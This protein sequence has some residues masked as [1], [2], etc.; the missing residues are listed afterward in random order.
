MQTI[1][2]AE[3]RPMTENH[4]LFTKAEEAMEK[5]FSDTSVELEM[6]LENMQALKD[7]I[8]ISISAL[9]V[10]IKNEAGNDY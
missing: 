7:G 2:R 8:E 3:E 1:I 5:V 6:A 10:D 9:K 4:I